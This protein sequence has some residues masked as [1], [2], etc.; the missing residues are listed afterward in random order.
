[1]T[2]FD[3]ARLI[4]LAI[5]GGV[6]VTWFVIH[7]RQSLG[8]TVQMAAAWGL[9]F[10][11]VI[12]AVG[13]WDDIRRAVRPS[14]AVVTGAGQVKVPR[15]PD[16]H[17]Y[18]TLMVNEKP[19]EFMVDTGASQV[20][21]TPEDARRVGLRLADLAYTG[22]AMTANGEVRTAPVKLDRVDL[23]PVF[24]KNVRAWVNQG[25]M[26]QSLLGMSYLQLWSKIEITGGSLVLTR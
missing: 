24:D 17:Y 8:K 3:P 21:L 23:G 22:R 19:V 2:D 6:L 26:D 14:L 7:N 25:D 13:L 10:L 9:I 20:V 15:A 18:L 1:M 11:G 16:G 12:A 4:Y 5:L